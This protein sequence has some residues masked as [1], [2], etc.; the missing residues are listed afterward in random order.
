M[1]WYPI[2]T[3][4]IIHPFKNYIIQIDIRNYTNRYIDIEIQNELKIP[5]T[6]GRL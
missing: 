3:Y 4:Y 6:M 2:N 5:Q 1:T